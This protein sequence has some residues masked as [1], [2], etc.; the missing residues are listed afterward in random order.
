MAVALKERGAKVTGIDPSQ[1]AIAAARRHAEA[2]GLEIDYRVSSGE[3][4]PFA[5]DVFDIVLCVDVLEHVKDLNRVLTEIRRV[6]RPNG[7]F[8][9]DTINRT[10]I[11]SFLM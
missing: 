4:L 3:N 8:L 2:D 7:A 6:L 10:R 1:P 9:F 11:A 5:N